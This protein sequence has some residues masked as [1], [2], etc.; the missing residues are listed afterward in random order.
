M[1]V[2]ARL[3]L[4]GA[5]LA[6]TFG[7]AFAAGDALVPERV[8]HDWIERAGEHSAI[9]GMDQH[10]APDGMDDPTPSPSKAAPSGEHD[11]GFP[12]WS[13]R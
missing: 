8:V 6:A 7:V 2:P 1:K 10:S 13:S 12:R 5:A 11:H 3:G 9:G 4:Y